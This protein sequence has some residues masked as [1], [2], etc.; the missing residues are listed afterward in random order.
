[1]SDEIRFTSLQFILWFQS[2]QGVG[3]GEEGHLSALRGESGFR[4]VK[5]WLWGQGGQWLGLR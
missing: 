3:V 4:E 5:V 1:M 2:A